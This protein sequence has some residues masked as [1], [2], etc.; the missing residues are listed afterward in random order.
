MDVTE[1]KPDFTPSRFIN[2]LVEAGLVTA[3]LVLAL[4]GLSWWVAGVMIGLASG[5]WGFVH[6]LRLS[7]MLRA[8]PAKA[9]GTATLAI[10][11]IVFVHGLGFGLG[12]AFHALIG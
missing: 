9:I 3:T 5:W 10:V 8:N 7:G 12:A 1:P 6:R 2:G 4:L 11:F